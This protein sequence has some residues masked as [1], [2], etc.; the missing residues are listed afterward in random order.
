MI[1]Y[2]RPQQ[3]VWCLNTGGR[4]TPRW[5][6]AQ[7]PWNRCKIPAS[8]NVLET[9][10]FSFRK[11]RILF[12]L[13]NFLPFGFSGFIDYLSSLTQSPAQHVRIPKT[14][15]PFLTTVQSTDQSPYRC[16]SGLARSFCV[17]H[18]VWYIIHFLFCWTYWE[19]RGG[20]KS[21][22]HSN[23]NPFSRHTVFTR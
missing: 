11:F 12:F 9:V 3:G 21:T 14:L 1:R 8:L 2:A 20:A 19:L 10:T 16:T 6:K 17:I 5:G 15:F 13:I 7:Y 22:T 23:L 4:W 18:D